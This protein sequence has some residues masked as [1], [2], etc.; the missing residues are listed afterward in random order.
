VTVG[1]WTPT[2]RFGKRQIR[3][4]AVHKNPPDYEKPARAFIML[5]E[6]R[7]KREKN[8]RLRGR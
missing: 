6:E 7:N 1:K 8:Q 4:V 3:I 2:D 5:A